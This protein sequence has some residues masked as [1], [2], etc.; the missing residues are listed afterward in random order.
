M[1]EQI[2]EQPGAE[3]GAP[4]VAGDG[5]GLYVAEVAG[6]GEPGVSDDPAVGGSSATT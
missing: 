1:L 5:D 3:P 6:R 2:G 4:L